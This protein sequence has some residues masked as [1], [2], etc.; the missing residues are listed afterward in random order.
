MKY[1]SK[2]IE[3]YILLGYKS[4]GNRSVEKNLLISG[5]WWC[6]SAVMVLVVYHIIIFT[7]IE[8]GFTHDE[9]IKVLYTNAFVM[10]LTPLVIIGT[11]FLSK[12]KANLRHDVT[13]KQK[14]QNIYIMIFSTIG[15][16]V[17]VVSA[18]FFLSNI[19]D[20]AGMVAFSGIVVLLVIV[21]AM[22]ACIG[23]YKVYLIRKF[24]PYLKNKIIMKNN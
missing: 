4:K 18:R 16:T 13:K 15:A 5:H 20:S 19:S 7:H 3:K 14:D 11:I 21:F 2:E 10:F 23:Y 9:Y 24:C 12:R 6:F 1:N 17:G 8:Y 22:C